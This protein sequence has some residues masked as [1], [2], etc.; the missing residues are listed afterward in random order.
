MRACL[1]LHKQLKIC[2]AELQ[3]VYN[4]TYLPHTSQNFQLVVIRLAA[5]IE[6]HFF[7]LCFVSTLIALSSACIKKKILPS[8]LRNLVYCWPFAVLPS[9]EMVR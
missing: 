6:Y 1:P 9:I 4:I 7:E 5:G 3:G 8:E 2:S